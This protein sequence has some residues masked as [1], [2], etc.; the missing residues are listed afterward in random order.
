MVYWCLFRNF[1]KNLQKTHIKME[2]TELNEKFRELHNELVNRVINF[3]KENNIDATDF[4]LGADGLD[5]SIPY[6]YWTPGTDSSFGLYRRNGRVQ[7]PILY[8]I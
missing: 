6:G 7:E 4:A 5:D 1:V 2:N 8:S 3:C